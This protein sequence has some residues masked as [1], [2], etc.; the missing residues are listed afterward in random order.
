MHTLRKAKAFQSWLDTCKYNCTNMTKNNTVTKH[1]SLVMSDY[2]PLRNSGCHMFRSLCF[3]R[4]SSLR[5]NSIVLLM[6]CNSGTFKAKQQLSASNLITSIYAGC[7]KKRSLQLLLKFWQSV[8]S[9]NKFLQI[10]V[11]VTETHNFQFFQPLS[12]TRKDQ[13]A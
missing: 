13:Q 7:S 12:W 3:C 2:S 4:C 8:R 5:K 1:F 6:P 9:E 11:V 10:S